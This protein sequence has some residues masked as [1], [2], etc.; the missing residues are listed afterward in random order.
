MARR[1]CRVNPRG[2]LAMLMSQRVE[3][4]SPPPG[5][6]D[7]TAWP[8]LPFDAWRD[9]C[10]T[11]HL[12]THVVGQVRRAQSPWTNRPWHVTLYVTPRGLTPSPIPYGATS[13]AITFDFV[14]HRLL[15]E[16]TAGGVRALPLRPRSVAQFYAGVMEA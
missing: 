6:T 3:G 10:A 2:I 15:I 16:T 11:L 1:A 4:T 7:A 13:F 5:P 8:A 9:T 12:W 14:A